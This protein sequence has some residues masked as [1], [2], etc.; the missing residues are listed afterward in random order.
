[1]TVRIGKKVL[2]QSSSTINTELEF[3]NQKS[4]G[5]LRQATTKNL[6]EFYVPEQ[7]KL[8]LGNV[9]MKGLK[10][11]MNKWIDQKLREFHEERE[12]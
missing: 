7:V 11:K 2:T 10:W 8:D 12:N 4:F 1:M 5:V 6:E 3:Q 9:S